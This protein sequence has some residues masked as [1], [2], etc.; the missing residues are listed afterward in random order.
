[1][2]GSNRDVPHCLQQVFR[3]YQAFLFGRMVYLDDLAGRL[4]QMTMTMQDLHGRPPCAVQLE[5][6]SLKSSR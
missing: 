2:M 3:D 6:W 5:Q 4:L 1:M